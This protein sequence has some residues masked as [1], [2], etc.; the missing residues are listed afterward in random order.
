[1]PKALDAKEPEHVAE[2]VA[3]LGL[4]HVV[5][6]SVDRDDLADGGARHFADVVIAPSAAPARRRRSR[7]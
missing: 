3:K 2:A 1:M 5:I 6:T 7:F 4:A